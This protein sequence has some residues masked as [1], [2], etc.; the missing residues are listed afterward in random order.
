MRESRII[1]DERDVFACTFAG[2][3]PARS[4]FG[5]FVAALVDAVI[6]GVLR[7][8]RFGRDDGEIAGERQRVNLSA[9]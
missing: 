5:T 7:L 6:R 8:G 3:R 1:Q 4:D 2:A 9:R